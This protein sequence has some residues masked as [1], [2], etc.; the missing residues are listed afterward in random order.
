M[1]GVLSFS[2]IIESFVLGV[3][4][5]S[6]AFVVLVVVG[7][8]PFHWS[9]PLFSIGGRDYYVPN[10][11][12]FIWSHHLKNVHHVLMGTLSSIYGNFME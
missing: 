3:L 10:Y 5:F 1:L 8:G 11:V 9:P 12:I 2:S 4:S 7:A 6:N